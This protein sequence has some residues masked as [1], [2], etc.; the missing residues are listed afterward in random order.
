MSE[1]SF[2]RR[3]RQYLDET[4]QDFRLLARKLDVPAPV[5][6]R[7]LISADDP[8]QYIIKRLNQLTGKRWNTV[9][10]V[11]DPFETGFD[12][13]SLSNEFMKKY[14]NLKEHIN[15]VQSIKTK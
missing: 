10:S 1:S 4:R 9:P 2:S 5:I 11:P 13:A 3:L 7:L 14:H 12:T 15:V 6:Q 8:P